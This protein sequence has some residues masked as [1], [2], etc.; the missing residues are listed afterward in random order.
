MTKD[1]FLPK[2]IR[3]GNLHRQ[4][5]EGYFYAFMAC[6]SDNGQDVSGLGN[7]LQEIYLDLGPSQHVQTLH[8]VSDSKLSASLAFK[9]PI[10]QR[11]Q[12][13]F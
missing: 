6:F 10:R 4:S 12:L 5:K 3:S 8:L 2:N 13:Y 9:V 11:I 1:L 7:P